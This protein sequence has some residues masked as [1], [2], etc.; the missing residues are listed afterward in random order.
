MTARAAGAD[1]LSV[2]I[3][4]DHPV[5]RSG[6]RAGLERGGLNV[7]AEASN[8]EDAVAAALRER[9]DVCLLD[10]RMPGNGIWA[11][12]SSEEELFDALRAGASGYL[13]KETDPERLPDLLHA[14]AD[15]EAPVPPR[16]VTRLIDEFRRRGRRRYV[17]LPRRRGVELTNRECEVLEL[18]RKGLD[19][20]DV[21]ERLFV[22][23]VTIRRHI[24]SLIRKLGAT[25]RDDAVRDG[26]SGI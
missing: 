1:V 25:S 17:P 19:P 22:S 11:A 4:D 7:C 13:L 6:V 2:V 24:S 3:A 20:A 15:G 21:A 14:A 16:L 5:T 9:P 23:K 12:S 10:I 26:C 18:L 8:G